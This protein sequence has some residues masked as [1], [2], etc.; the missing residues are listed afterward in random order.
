MLVGVLGALTGFLY[1]NWNPSR[2]IMGDTGSQFLGVFLA[3]T[4]ILFFWNYRDEGSN[5]FIQLKQFVVPLFFFIVPLID[6]MTVTIRRLM[7]KQS[8]FVGG[9]DHITHHLVYFG[10]SEKQTALALM[11]LSLTSIP[12][13]LL[14][15]LQIIE[16]NWIATFAAFGYFFSVFTVI[17]IIYNIGKG[18][19][20]AKQKA[21]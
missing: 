10:L 5:E 21:K 1:F 8:P 19:N 14:Y 20:L 15:I 17:Q 16:W 18:K 2:I 9:K 13:A 6:T 3:A 7:R 12:L 11:L 4:S